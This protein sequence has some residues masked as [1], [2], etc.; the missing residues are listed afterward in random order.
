MEG[1]P[2]M[3]VILPEIRVAASELP[4]EFGMAIKEYILIHFDQEPTDYDR[5]IQEICSLRQKVAHPTPDI[6]MACILK[7]YYGQLL[8]MKSRFPLEEDDEIVRMNVGGDAFFAWADQS[9]EMPHIAAHNDINFESIKTAFMNFQC[10]AWPLQ[11]IRDNIRGERFNTM[12]FEKDHLTFHM[13]IL[14]AQAQECLIE[15]S[16]IDHRSHEVVA[17]LAV[18]LR[19]L[20]QECGKHLETSSLSD[21]VTSSRYREWHRTCTAKSDLFGAIAALHMGMKHEDEKQMGFRLAYYAHA[22]NHMKRALLI[23]DKDK[24]AELHVSANFLYDVV[25][26]KEQNARKE[27]DLIYHERIPKD[28]EISLKEAVSLYEEEKAKLKRTVLEKVNAKDIELHEFLE[29]FGFDRLTADESGAIQLPDELLQRNASFNTQPDSIP[30]LLEKLSNVSANGE[31]TANRVADVLRRLNGIDL[32]SILEDEGYKTIQAEMG[33]M[34]DQLHITRTRNSEEQRRIATQSDALHLLALPLPRL[35]EKLS[36][37]QGKPGPS[38]E[39]V[40]LRQMLDKTNEMSAQRVL[41]LQR[42]D[43]EMKRD[44]IGKRLLAERDQNN[45]ATCAKELEKHGTTIQFIEQNLGAQEKILHALTEANAD[46]SDIR[47]KMEREQA[48]RLERVAQLVSAF[49]VYLEVLRN[50]NSALNVLDSINKRVDKILPALDAMETANFAEK[51]KRDAEKRAFA[52]K[53]ERLKREKE[54]REAMAEFSHDAMPSPMTPPMAPGRPSPASGSSG[55]RDYYEFFKSKMGQPPSQPAM[56][57]HHPYAPMPQ[58]MYQ[59]QPPPTNQQFSRPYFPPAHHSP[60]MPQPHPYQHPHPVEHAMPT[61]PP[62][63]PYTPPVPPQT[64]A[65][66]PYPNSIHT[67][68]AQY[69][70]RPMPDHQHYNGPSPALDR[71]PGVPQPY[72]QPQTPY[73]GYSPAASSAPGVTN[74]PQHPIQNGHQIQHQAQQPPISLPPVQHQQLPP[75]NYGYQ[76][77]PASVPPQP[78]Q[79]YQQQQAQPQFAHPPVGPAPPTHYQQQQH[80]PQLQNQQRPMQSMQ[81]LAAPVV[82][83][84]PM[85]A[86]QGFQPAGQHLSGGTPNIPPTSSHGTSGMPMGQHFTG[87]QPAPTPPPPVSKPGDTHAVAPSPF[88]PIQPASAATTAPVIQPQPVYGAPAGHNALSSAPWQQARAQPQQQYSSSPWHCGVNWPNQKQNF[89]AQPAAQYASPPMAQPQSQ[90]QQPFAAAQPPMNNVSQGNMDLLGSL[91]GDLQLPAALQPVSGPAAEPR[92]PQPQDAV[93]SQSPT[94]P[95]NFPNVPISPQQPPISNPKCL[96]VSPVATMPTAVVTPMPKTA[97]SASFNSSASQGTELSISST[98]SHHY[99]PPPATL[100]THTSSASVPPSRSEAEEKRESGLPVNDL[101]DPSK[102]CIGPDS[103]QKLEKKLLHASFH[104]NAARPNLDP[105]DPINQL[106]PFWK[107]K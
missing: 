97:S 82:P 101:L 107:N 86:P 28:D 66:P 41:L 29:R 67:S 75:V 81:P 52:E 22:M 6:E 90:P 45:T 48:A 54:A 84:G 37:S 11:Q 74:A 16:L 57:N 23:L 18:H 59:P 38:A 71:S 73:P 44:N 79:P 36:D 106:D 92:P 9:G 77:A 89:G 47:H 100:S 72:Q 78:H 30:Q 1:M 104:G 24:R 102:F 51:E 40:V 62:A 58:P 43:D 56:A 103:R 61:P 4:P 20:Y 50:A 70:N 55:R 80:Q 49:D 83:S 93:V 85:P 21:S 17:K 35:T 14:L 68:P 64:A 65:A 39:G 88:H 60:S 2:R 32:P 34:A 87:H 3:P 46:F 26:A 13:N 99:G 63:H 31:T 33:R 53:M 94:Q 105:N 10:A 76:Q 12:D 5:A 27:N 42:L 91:L 8:M 98:I 19:D 25:A 96:S 15:K 69:A 95:N 7:R